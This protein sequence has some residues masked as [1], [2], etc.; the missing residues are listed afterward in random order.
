MGIIITNMIMTLHVIL[1]T[2]YSTR[3]SQIGCYLVGITGVFATFSS[4]SYH[5]FISELIESLQKVYNPKEIKHMK[6]HFYAVIAGLF[7]SMLSVIIEDISLD[8]RYTITNDS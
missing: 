3:R 8:V 7:F 2:L 5:Y 6:Y 1:S 4:A